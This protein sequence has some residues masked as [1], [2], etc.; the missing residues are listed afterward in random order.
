MATLLYD[1]TVFTPHAALERHAV[2]V[3]DDGKI[4]FVG[5]VEDAPQV[6][7]PHL[8]L[9]GR[10]LAPGFIDIHVHGG[11]GVSFGEGDLA[12]GLDAYSK[13]VAGNGV[14]GF[15][16]SLAGP[17]AAS[18]TSM[19]SGYAKI[20]NRDVP[21]AEPLGLHLEG[22]FINREKKG[23]FNPAWIRPASVEETE[24]YLEAGKGKILQM[25]L[26]PEMPNAEAVAKLLRQ[27]GV[28]AALG[29]SNTDYAT[30]SKALQGNFSHVTH[31]F[32]AQSSFAHRSPSVFGAVLASDNVTAELIGDGIHVHPAAM[33]V[34]IRCLGTDRVVLITDAIVGAGLKDGQYNLVGQ[35]VTVKDGRATLSNGTLAGSIGTMDRCVRNVHHLAGYSLLDAVKMASLNPARA[36]G[37]ADRLGAIYPGKDACMTVI[38]EDVNVYLTMVKGKIVHNNL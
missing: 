17:D 21:G 24:G 3:S 32:N 10:I 37:L 1:A 18:F 14:T 13:W 6:N 25:T 2:V 11:N 33:K 5:K 29:H 20:L 28:V 7:G 19:I 31:T 12:A 26:A 23:A 35:E 4:A 36:M 38:D 27:A 9:R 34:L 8:N 22:P 30:A 15:L 16:L